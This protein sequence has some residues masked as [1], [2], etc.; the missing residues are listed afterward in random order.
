ML[1]ILD[2]IYDGHKHL[3]PRIAELQQRYAE[4]SSELAVWFELYGKLGN[5]LEKVLERGDVHEIDVV[6]GAAIDFERHEPFA[7]EP[8]PDMENEQ[9]KEVTRKGY[10]YT[11]HDGERQVLRAAQVVVVKNENE[12]KES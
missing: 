5:E 10:E 7:V 6:P 9:I 2:G 3:T 12:T 8:E 4:Q 1:P 11:T